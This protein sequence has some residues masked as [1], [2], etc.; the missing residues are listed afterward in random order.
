MNPL[1]WFGDASL[2]FL[3]PHWLWALLALPLLGWLWRSRRKRSS[4]WRGAVDAHLLPHL[5]ES[6]G[7]RRSRFAIIAAVL[8]YV[9][10]VCALSGPSWR[11]S[12]QPLWQGKTP[13]V[14]ALDLSSRMLASD[15]PPTR[16]AHAR[17]KLAS[18]LRQRSGGQIGLVVYADDA[19]TVAPMTDDPR[20][21][22]VFLDALAPDVMPG[23]GQRADRAIEWSAKLLRQAGFERGQIL[24]LSD[25]ADGNERRA[26]AK[27]AADGYTVS[28][29]GL[30]TAAGA[31]F[32]RPDGRIVMARM[33]VDSLRGLAA[34][35]GGRYAAISNDD[36]DLR[37]LRILAPGSADAGT[38]QGEKTLTREDNGYWLL[39]ALMLLALLAFRR[40]SGV[41]AVLLLCLWLPMA[42]GHAQGLW[43][44]PDQVEHERMEQGTQA[45]RKGEFE[46]AA[47]LYQRSQGADAQYNLGNAMAR[48]G[49]Y[50]EAIKAYDSA[51]KLQP[52]M[53]DAIANKRAVE[54]AMKRKPPPKNGDKGD[55][56]SQPKDGKDN[57][58]DKGKGDS[59]PQGDPSQQPKPSKPDDA[60][61]PNP[62]QPPKDPDAQRKADAA[63]RE[64]IQREL[65][66]QAKQPGQKTAQAQ[67]QAKP[68]TPEQRERRVANDAWLK[69]VPDDPGSLLREK[70][71]I[72]YERR[73]N[74]AL[75]GD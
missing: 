28:A 40:R 67:Q 18:L 64:K 29:L 31:A 25:R 5:L 33:D 62:E 70:F 44:R 13:L 20:N 59:S 16:L 55:S 23:D 8:A 51:L 7:G 26:A 21:L 45:Y 12:E 46:R 66:R 19:Y 52:G 50:E 17:A 72:E 1:T 60:K 32:Q 3:R 11:Q 63:Q 27:A 48:Q 74:Q 47:Q 22:A 34:D 30:G 38:A 15:L 41:A 49:R 37:A 68:L 9:I 43:K 57:K 71:K 36:S 61:K 42:P 24:I 39:P 54:A 10:A 69:R 73:Q 58:N 14:I 6:R 53:A 65:E 35:G 2:V 4:V 56:K 75:R